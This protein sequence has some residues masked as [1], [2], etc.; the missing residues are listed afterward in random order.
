MEKLKNKKSNSCVYVVTFYY[1][2][3][4]LTNIGCDNSFSYVVGDQALKD[5][6]DLRDK[7]GCKNIRW[8]KVD[9]KNSGIIKKS[10]DDYD[11]KNKT[12]N[13]VVLESR[14]ETLEML[15]SE[16]INKCGTKHGGLAYD[17][18]V[19]KYS[20]GDELWRIKYIDNKKGYA[21]LRNG[22]MVDKE[23]V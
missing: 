21:I 17:R 15:R 5:E 11:L 4:S 9:K 7:E 1:T 22:F 13:D 2:D 14:I 20:S 19:R 8:H 10:F 12:I 23:E 18:L 3:K 16:L 6:L